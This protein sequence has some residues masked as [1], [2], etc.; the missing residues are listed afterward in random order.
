[1]QA[2]IILQDMLFSTVF[3]N[4]PL[5]HFFTSTCKKMLMHGSKQPQF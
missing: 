4:I 5:N 2:G 3:T 1:M